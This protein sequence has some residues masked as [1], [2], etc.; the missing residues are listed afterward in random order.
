[1]KWKGYGLWRSI[2]RE[3]GFWSEKILAYEILNELL[4]R[5]MDVGTES[6]IMFSRH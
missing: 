5:I 6:A 4:L 1:M 2:S 3:T